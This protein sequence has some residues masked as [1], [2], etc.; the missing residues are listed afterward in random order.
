[1]VRSH[2]DD[3]QMVSA[4]NQTTSAVTGRPR[5]WHRGGH[6]SQLLPTIRSLGLITWL[7]L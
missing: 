3:R 5:W 7:A 2:D 6:R 1:V 4:P